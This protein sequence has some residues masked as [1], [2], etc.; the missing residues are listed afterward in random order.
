MQPQTMNDLD[1]RYLGADQQ[2]HSLVAGQRAAYGT[3]SGW[4]Q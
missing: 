2:V 4:D 1:G 3:F